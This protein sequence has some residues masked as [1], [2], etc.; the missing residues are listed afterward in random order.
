MSEL[1]TENL[2]KYQEFLELAAIQIRQAPT[3]ARAAQ[4]VN[5]EA[6]SLYW[7]LGEY[8]IFIKSNMLGVNRL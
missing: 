3:R 8:I 4:A 5:K 7:W 2:P 1:S 6:M